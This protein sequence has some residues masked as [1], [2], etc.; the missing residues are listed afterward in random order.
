MQEVGF[1]FRGDSRVGKTAVIIQLTKGHWIDRIEP[2]IEDSYRKMVEIDNKKILLQFFDT[3]EM[4]ERYIRQTDVLLLMYNIGNRQSFDYLGKLIQE[5]KE[6]AKNFHIVI[7]GNQCDT[8]KR[9]VSEQDGK[10]LANEINALFFEISA[11]NYINLDEMLVTATTLVL[12]TSKKK[13]S[14]QIETKKCILM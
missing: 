2:T 7:A 10:E 8:D 3:N 13:P 1:L 4:D 9:E 12:D 5:A 11:K 14:D 6:E